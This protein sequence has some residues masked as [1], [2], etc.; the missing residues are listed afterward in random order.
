MVNTAEGAPASMT[1]VDQGQVWGEWEH[2]GET[3]LHISPSTIDR[4]LRANK[5]QPRNRLYERTNRGLYCGTKF[6]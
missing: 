5:R 1:S 6:G 2:G 4:S 3:S